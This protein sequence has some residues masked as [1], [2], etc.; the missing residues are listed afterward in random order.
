MTNL[1]FRD[2]AVNAAWLEIVLI[3]Q[4]L[5][6]WTKALCLD[7]ELARCE[8]KRLRYRLLHLAGRLAVHARQTNLHPTATGPGHASWPPPSRARPRCRHRRA[9]A[10]H[11]PKPTAPRSPAHRPTRPTRLT[12]KLARAAPDTPAINGLMHDHG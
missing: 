10:P 2:Y 6:A 7:G 1:P 12:R 4:D 3:A 11:H 5:I 9:N 8:P